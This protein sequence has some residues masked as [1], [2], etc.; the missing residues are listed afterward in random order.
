[1]IVFRYSDKDCCLTLSRICH[2]V[3]VQVN[4]FII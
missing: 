1:M 2:P 3:L 4:L